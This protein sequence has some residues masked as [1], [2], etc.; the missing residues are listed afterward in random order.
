MDKASRI[1][2]GHHAA[3]LAE[4]IC[5]KFD[6]DKAAAT[7]VS[8]VFGGRD[9]VLVPYLPWRMV[10][11]LIGAHALAFLRSLAE[12]AV[13]QGVFCAPDSFASLKPAMQ[14]SLWV[15]RWQ[16]RLSDWLHVSLSRQLLRLYQPAD[17]FDLVYG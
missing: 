15:Q 4:D 8:S 14:V 16:Q 9:H 10:G 2:A 6:A 7:P 13:S 11:V 5:R 3:K 1:P 12:H 17:S